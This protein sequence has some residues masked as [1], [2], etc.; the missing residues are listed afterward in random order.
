MDDC[1]LPPADGQDKYGCGQSNRNL[2]DARLFLSAHKRDPTDRLVKNARR[3]TVNY[4]IA[5][6]DHAT[7]LI[8]QS[9]VDA[10]A[11]YREARVRGKLD[12]TPYRGGICRQL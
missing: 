5:G 12:S 8:G 2:P 1:P 6:L 10:H 4:A 7:F 3:G 9:D 11:G